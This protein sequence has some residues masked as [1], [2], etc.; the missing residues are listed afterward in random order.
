M[1]AGEHAER[2]AL[3]L[4]L[5]KHCN[6]LAPDVPET[7]SEQGHVVSVMEETSLPEAL[8]CLVRRKR[9]GLTSFQLSTW[10]EYITYKYFVNSI[11]IQNGEGPG[12]ALTSGRRAPA[13]AGFVAGRF[14]VKFFVQQ[15]SEFF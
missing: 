10:R 2:C 7:R 6:L 13:G 5:R 1:L 4:G 9:L 15:L 12:G 11:K 3:G 14:F 8:G